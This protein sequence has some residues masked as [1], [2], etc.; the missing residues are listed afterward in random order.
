MEDAADARYLPTGH[1]VFLRQGTLMVVPFDLGRHKITGQPVPVIT[2]VMQA[3]NA[4]DIGYNSAAGQF[5]ISESGW[6]IYAKGGILPDQENSLV[7]M[8]QKGTAEPIT[9][10]KAPLFLPRLS[11]DGQRIAFTTMAQ[12]WVYDLKQGTTTRLTND[13]K[14]VFPNWT[15]DGNRVAFAWCR[16]GGPNLFWQLADGSSPMERLTTSDSTQYPGSWSH[17]GNTL[18]FVDLRANTNGDIL[19]LDLPSR[20]ITPFLNSSAEEWYPEFSPDGR[21]MAYGSNDSLLKEVYVRPFPGP[22][23]KRVIAEGGTEPLWSRNG[24]QLFYRWEQGEV[25]VVD[26]RTDGGFSA[27]KPR[28]LFK[29]PG[30]DVGYPIRGWDLSLDG[31]RFLMVKLGEA[32][33]TPVT[34]MVLVMNWF[35][36]LKR[37]APTGKK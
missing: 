4:P 8:D 24:K 25:W 2:N 29:A 17:D 27:G 33:P 1:L 5:S 35:E 21:W 7:W 3:L 26:V 36:E 18:A 15:P 32:K 16:S 23:G 19:L 12:V 13:G 9:S 28:L 30:F 14:A 10:Y 31:Q 22:G 6:L 20:R 34:E 11:P 37:L